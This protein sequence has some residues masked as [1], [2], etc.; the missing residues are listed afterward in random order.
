MEKKKM[1]NFDD[2]ILHIPLKKELAKELKAEGVV[3]RR[4]TYWFLT[5]Y[6]ES[7]RKMKLEQQRILDA[8]VAINPSLVTTK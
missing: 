7:I 5:N 8:T 1:T 2:T 4:I 3:I 6:L